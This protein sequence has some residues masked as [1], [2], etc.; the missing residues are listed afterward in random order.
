M[1]S[2]A[3]GSAPNSARLR[4]FF[5]AGRRIM[6]KELRL[7]GKVAIITGA[8]NGFGNGASY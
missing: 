8:G 1:A 2:S 6:N 4:S 7:E 5:N 3:L